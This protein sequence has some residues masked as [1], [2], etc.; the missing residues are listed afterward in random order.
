MIFFFFC[1]GEIVLLWDVCFLE[2]FVEI[3]MEDMTFRI[4]GGGKSRVWVG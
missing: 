4:W 1:F 3:F 2:I